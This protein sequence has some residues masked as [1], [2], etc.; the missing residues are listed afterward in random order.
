MP[1]RSPLLRLLT[2]VAFTAMVWSP[3]DACAG[4]TPT[5]AELAQARERF[6]A[7]RKLEDGGHWAEALTQ[8]QRVAEVKMTPQVRFHIALC[9][10]NVGLWT[11]ALDGYA[12]AVS[13]AGAGAPEV[14]KEANEH[15]RKLEALV[16]TLSLRVQSPAPNDE[17]YLDRRRIPIDDHPLPV[18]V[19]PGP[20]TAELQRGGAV[21]A[22]EIF[23]LEPKGSR[24]VELKVGSI[25]PSA[26]VPSAPSG[27]PLAPAT[28]DPP[29]EGRAQRIVGWSAIGLGAASAVV[30]GVFIGMHASAKSRL[31]EQC[32][33]LTQ[34]APAVASIV[35]EGKRDAALVNVF[36]IL[37]GVATITG[38]TL[39][40]SAPSPAAPASGRTAARFDLAPAVGPDTFGLVAGGVF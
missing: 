22:R 35:S 20:H 21:V 1:V 5:D 6:A 31:E 36:G 13:E 16:P 23:V 37:G 14:V 10:E 27:Q 19:D 3:T 9:M 18:R 12:Q 8:F 11:Q 7:G 15:A 33:G 26:E 28:P 40:L 38:V 39:L 2:A 4:G 24:R 34:C 25:T 17:L 30:M 32:P 29:V